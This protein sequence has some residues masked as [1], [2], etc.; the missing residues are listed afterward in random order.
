MGER[1]EWGVFRGKLQL[2]AVKRRGSLYCSAAA[3]LSCQAAL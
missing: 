1:I 2:K 3:M